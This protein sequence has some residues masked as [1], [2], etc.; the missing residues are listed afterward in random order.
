MSRLR[1]GLYAGLRVLTGVLLIL[2]GYINTINF[3]EYLM[4]VDQYFVKVRF[5]DFDILRMIIPFLPFVNFAIGLFVLL[6]FFTR[7]VLVTGMLLYVFLTLFMMDAK[8]FDQVFYHAF[9]SISMIILV[10]SENY[11]KYSLDR[12]NLTSHRWF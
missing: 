7:R 6:G 9:V 1:S 8:A 11:N 12:M 3:H 10:L 5:F 4:V 2:H